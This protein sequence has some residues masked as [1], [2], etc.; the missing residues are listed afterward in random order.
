MQARLRDLLGLD[1]GQNAETFRLLRE[2]LDSPMGVV[3]FVGAGLSIPCGMPGWTQF[4]L[5]MGDRIENRQAIEKHLRDSEFEEAAQAIADALGPRA[6]AD[7]L[8]EFFGD[9]RLMKTGLSGPVLRVPALTRGPVLT[10][11][12]DHVLEEA[13]KRCERP[14]EHRVWGAKPDMLAGALHSDK[15]YL[16]KL[17]GDVLDRQDRI[18][19]LKDYERHYGSTDVMKVNLNQPLPKLLLQVFTSRTLLFLGCSLEVDR[20][21]QLIRRVAQTDAA[22]PPHYAV[23]EL[24]RTSAEIR[25]RAQ[26]LSVHNIRPL[27]FPSGQYETIDTLL[28]ALTNP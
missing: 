8:T 16:I 9:D 23:V 2:Q 6:L 10:T 26:F 11:N 3:P 21:V 12:F 4:L 15:P 17:H 1:H 14:Y 7:R 19:T 25:A 13:F 20:T 27:W 22:P 28:E 5:D 24:P 18:L